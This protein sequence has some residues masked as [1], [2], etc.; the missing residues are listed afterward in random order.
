[1]TDRPE[2]IYTLYPVFK[3]SPALRTEL[4]DADDRRDRPQ[5]GVLQPAMRPRRL[6]EDPGEEEHD[7]DEAEGAG[8]DPDPQDLVVGDVVPED[9]HLRQVLDDVERMTEA[10]APRM[11]LDGV[12]EIVPLYDAVEVGRVRR[13]QELERA[14]ANLPD[15]TYPRR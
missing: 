9:P 7:H 12:A 11:R 10:D 2:T 6:G 3:A 8:L 13:V 15:P 5:Q 14:V 4:S 1:M